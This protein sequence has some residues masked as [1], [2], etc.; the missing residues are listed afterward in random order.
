MQSIHQGSYRRCIREPRV[1]RQKCSVVQ[2]GGGAGRGGREGGREGVGDL[3][4]DIEGLYAVGMPMGCCVPC[5]LRA[6][7]REHE[8][9]C[10]RASQSD[11][12]VCILPH[13]PCTRR[14]LVVCSA[15]FGIGAVARHARIRCLGAS[16]CALPA[17]TSA[18]APDT[19]TGCCWSG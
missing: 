1:L 9:G 16:T 14:V 4:L 15:A 11:M 7:T 12:G 5:W 13:A 18:P 19:S 8:E 17:P 10:T 3:D 2:E 6:A